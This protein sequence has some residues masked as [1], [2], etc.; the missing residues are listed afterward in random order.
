MYSYQNYLRLLPI[1]CVFWLDEK[2]EIPNE[3]K[4]FF[5]RIYDLPINRAFL[6]KCDNLGNSLNFQANKNGKIYNFYI[7]LLKFIKKY[8]FIKNMLNIIKIY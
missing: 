5:Q 8:I 1:K 6:R 4:K 3:E 2:Q 7:K